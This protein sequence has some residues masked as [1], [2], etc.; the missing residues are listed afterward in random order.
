MEQAREAAD[1]IEKKGGEMNFA[2]SAIAS[3]ESEELGLRVGESKGDATP[4]PKRRGSLQAS[5]AW[6]GRHRPR[7]IFA[8]GR[9]QKAAMRRVRPEENTARANFFL[10]PF[11]LNKQ[12]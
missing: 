4:G 2:G 11:I 5:E 10:R 6:L 3:L 7:A 12:T 8:R 9:G 1:C